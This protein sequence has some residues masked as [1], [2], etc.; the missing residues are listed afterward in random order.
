VIVVIVPSARW[1]RV[2]VAALLVLPLVIVVAL[3]A[4]TWIMLPFLSEPR[5]NAVL[6]FVSYLIDWIKAISGS[7]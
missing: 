5:R 2:A 7:P 1:Q 4:L 6:Q 3:S